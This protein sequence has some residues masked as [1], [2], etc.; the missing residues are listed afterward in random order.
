MNMFL[1]HNMFALLNKSF[2]CVV[3]VMLILVGNEQGGSSS[4]PR[5]G[6]LRSKSK[7]GDISRR[8]PECS[9]FNSYYTEM[10][11][12]RYSIPWIA[13][14]YPWSLPFNAEVASNT[15]FEFLVW[16]YLG[17]KFRVEQS[18]NYSIAALTVGFIFLLTNWQHIS[19]FFFNW[20]DRF[21]L[22]FLFV[23]VPGAF[24]FLFFW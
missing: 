20:C 16:V 14:L 17:L 6:C 1:V 22:F 12:G 23:L 3:R 7:A 21:G 9:L 4:N 11:G 15:I 18:C 24:F 10:W 2:G 19:W 5:W 8:W 13:P